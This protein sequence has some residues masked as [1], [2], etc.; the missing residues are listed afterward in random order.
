MLIPLH[1]AFEKYTP[2]ALSRFHSR[3]WHKR[4][5]NAVELFI[6]SIIAA[7]NKYKLSPSKVVNKNMYIFKS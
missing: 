7:M 5:W 4:F 3:R 6:D 1:Q 2:V